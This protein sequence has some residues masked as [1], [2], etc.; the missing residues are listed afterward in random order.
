MIQYNII[1]ILSAKRY[2]T[3][4]QLDYN[5]EFKRRKVLKVPTMIKF[6]EN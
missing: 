2:K 1:H 6:D 4:I 5:M 3:N